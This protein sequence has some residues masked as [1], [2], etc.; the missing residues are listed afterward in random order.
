MSTKSCKRRARAHSR[1]RQ[2]PFPTMVRHGDGSHCP[3]VSDYD[4][5][6]EDC[7]ICNH[8]AIMEPAHAPEQDQI[9]VRTRPLNQRE[10]LDELVKTFMP[11]P[12]GC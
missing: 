4:H 10:L 7:P 12:A 3:N 9:E 11:F 1:R 6:E 8:D 5:D 2:H